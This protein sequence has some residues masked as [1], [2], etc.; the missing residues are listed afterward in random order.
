[1]RALCLDYC[2]LTAESPAK[3]VSFVSS[4]LWPTLT[5]LMQ[6]LPAP[7]QATHL[8]SIEHGNQLRRIS[9]APRFVSHR[10]ISRLDYY[11]STSITNEGGGMHRI[12][13]IY[14]SNGWVRFYE[15][16]RIL[17]DFATP[18]S[19]HF[20]RQDDAATYLCIVLQHMIERLVAGALASC[21]KP[22]LRTKYGGSGK[23][24]HPG[25]DMQPR[26]F[27]VCFPVLAGGSSYPIAN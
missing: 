13:R 21:D 24:V 10:R 11:M 4:F 16:G 25:T 9:I 26:H 17:L 27:Q 15:S 1:M 14:K 8:Q 23:D 3:L 12:G 19:F 7:V 6:S 22:E 20:V 5:E 2:N 18:F